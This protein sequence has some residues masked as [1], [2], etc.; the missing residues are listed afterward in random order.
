MIGELL[1]ILAIGVIAGGIGIAFG[2]FFLAPR[3][4]RLTERKDEASH[5][6]PD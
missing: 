5:D 3:L 2:I 6:G 1:A 4:S